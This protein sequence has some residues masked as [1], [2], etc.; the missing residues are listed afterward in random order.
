MELIALDIRQV[1]CAALMSSWTLNGIM[2]STGPQ[3]PAVST[4]SQSHAPESTLLINRWLLKHPMRVMVWA[5]RSIRLI[6]S[7]DPSPAMMLP[8][9]SNRI[10]LGQLM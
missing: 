9:E 8:D 3:T 2:S 6:A 4:A 10:T 7:V 5:E 1:Q